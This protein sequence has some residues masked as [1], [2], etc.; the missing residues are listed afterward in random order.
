MLLLLW[1]DLRQWIGDDRIMFAV[2]VS[3]VNFIFVFGLSTMYWLFWE[4]QLFQKYKINPNEFPDKNRLLATARDVLVGNFTVVPAL[5]YFAVFPVLEW[6]VGGEELFMDI[7]MLPSFRTV[8]S[9]I[10]VL[11]AMTD[12]FHYWIHRMFHA[13]KFLYI[14]F[15]K[16]HHTYKICTGVVA[17]HNHPVES[18]LMALT[19]FLCHLVVGPHAFTY[20]IWIALWV[21]IAIYTHSGYD[22]PYSPFA[23]WAD[24]HDFHHTRNVGCFGVSPFWDR[25]L[26]TDA[27]Y[28][29]W[30]ETQRAT[31]SKRV[32]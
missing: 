28:T 24:L 21:T 14:N 12:T 31:V 32:S 25:V 13:N 16:E 4:L 11:F 19:D 29:S 18:T 3:S 7:N 22:F 6:R 30:N 5:C 15:H 8:I 10:M 1:N 9:Q 2:L 26:G 23:G 20:C 27:A 17:D